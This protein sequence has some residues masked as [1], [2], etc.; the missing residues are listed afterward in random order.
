MK[1]LRVGVVGLGA[2]GES[3]LRAY[4]GI[5]EVEVVAVAS[6][7]SERAREIAATYGI[8]RSYG[9]YEEITSDPEIDAISVTTAEG[10]H[11]APTVMALAAGKH[12]LVEKP[13]AATLDDALAMVEAERRSTAFLMPGHILR[14][15]AKFAALKSA[16]VS[17]E[18]GSIV[19]MNA[20][21]NRPRQLISSHGRVHPALVTAIH[22]IDIML[23]L[24]QERVRSVRAHHRLGTTITDA[25]GIWMVL[26]FV[27]GAVALLETAWMLPDHAGLG[28][29]DAFSVIGSAGLARVQFE[30]PGLRIW[31]EAG[32]QAP[33]VSYEP[34]VH[35]V[36]SGA[37]RDEL[38]TFA[39]HALNGTKPEI[40]RSEDGVNALAVVLA[41]IASAEQNREVD[42]NY[43]ALS[44]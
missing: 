20:R 11:L 33:D 44:R 7:S 43:P 36:V 14:F 4:R 3:H 29:D 16:V 41:A 12:V 13:F 1:R 22:D 35:G 28:T 37:L 31:S 34:I 2:F 15:E 25:H 17:Q 6:R 21:R 42:V 32:S 8:P 9:S 26:E 5:P 27:G 38:A 18:L 40:V 10:D 30:V 19:S 23:W 24:M 39:K